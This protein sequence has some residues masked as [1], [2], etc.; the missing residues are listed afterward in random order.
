VR[1]EARCINGL[2]E[3]ALDRSDLDGA[4]RHYEQALA[5]YQA[6]PDPYSAGWTLV[7]LARLDPPGSERARHWSAARE[8]W[9]S[10]GREDL[11]ESVSAEFE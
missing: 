7:S 3:I 11:V 1:G 10:T 2:G 6:I 9:T 5:L 8:A 4:R